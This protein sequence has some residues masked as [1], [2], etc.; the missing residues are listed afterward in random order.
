LIAA[1]TSNGLWLFDLQTKTWTR[2]GSGAYPRWLPDGRRALA[3]LHGRIVLVD[4]V[5]Q[6]TSDVYGEPQRFIGALA[7]AAGGR[8]VYFTSAVTRSQIWTMR[9]GAR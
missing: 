4:T 2:I 9:L 7:I 6:A 1:D 3:V 5:A 8:R